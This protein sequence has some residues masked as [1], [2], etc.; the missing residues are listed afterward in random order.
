VRTAFYGTFRSISD[1]STTPVCSLTPGDNEVLYFNGSDNGWRIGGL[2][3]DNMN[4]LIE[5]EIVV[6]A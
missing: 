5:Y 3:K 1:E 4:Q 6:A 2:T